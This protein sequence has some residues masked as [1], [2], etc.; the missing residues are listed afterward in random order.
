MRYITDKQL[1]K[2]VLNPVVKDAKFGTIEKFIPNY[3][4]DK[5]DYHNKNKWCVE[6]TRPLVTKFYDT[7][8]ITNLN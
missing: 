5:N 2:E 3:W 7:E 1:E 4:Q 6:P 8:S